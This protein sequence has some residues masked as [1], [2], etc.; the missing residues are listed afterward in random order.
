MDGVLSASFETNQKGYC[1]TLK[2][3][4]RPLLVGNCRGIILNQ[5]SEFGGAFHGFRATIHSM[6]DSP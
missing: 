4:L 1:T 5:G 2:L 6:L 3:W